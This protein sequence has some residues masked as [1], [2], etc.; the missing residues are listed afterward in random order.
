MMTVFRFAF[1]FKALVPAVLLAIAFLVPRQSP[2]QDSPP[3]TLRATDPE[4]AADTLAAGVYPVD[5]LDTIAADD[6]TQTERK[7]PIA[8]LDLDITGGVSE[9]YQRVLSDRLRQEL[10]KTGRYFVIEQ[11]RMQEILAEQSFQLAGCISDECAV[12]VGRLLGVRQMV[13]GSIGRVGSI[14]TINLRIIDIETAQ[15]IAADN[16]DCNCPIEEVLTDRLREAAN[17][18]AGIESGTGDAGK[19][20]TGD[21]PGQVDT[22]SR[23]RRMPMGGFG[24]IFREMRRAGVRAMGFRFGLGLVPR[25]DE[26]WFGTL[27]NG[28]F[29]HFDHLRE[30]DLMPSLELGG[31]GLYNNSGGY[32]ASVGIA[33]IRFKLYRFTPDRNAESGLYY[34]GGIGLFTVSRSGMNPEDM[35]WHGTSAAFG[36]EAMGGI[37]FDLPWVVF[38]HSLF[39]FVEADYF[40]LIS[41]RDPNGFMSITGGIGIRI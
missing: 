9:S 1:H 41:S 35:E 24:S 2:A 8:V 14:H 37:I 18:I 3:D 19:M 20:E 22:G 17:R 26:G 25:G 6:G 23:H 11:Q 10:F 21:E 34:G 32:D 7:I 36:M 38:D 33:N 31:G 4:G 12:E 39:T 13:A 30:Y 15:V 5:T 27:G 28:I 40:H 16:V 29:I